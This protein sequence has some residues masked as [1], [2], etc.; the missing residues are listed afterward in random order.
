VVNLILLFDPEMVIIGGGVAGAGDFLLEPVRRAVKRWVVPYFEREVPV[1]RS[2]LGGN[3]NL[4]GA[5][6]LALDEIQATTS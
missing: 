4:M 6:A 2:R 1:V 5:V 3:S